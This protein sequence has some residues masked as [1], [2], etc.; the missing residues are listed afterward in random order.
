MAHNLPFEVSLSHALKGEGAPS[1]AVYSDALREANTALTAYVNAV[2]PLELFSNAGRIDD[3]ATASIVAKTLGQNTS[4]IYVLGTGGSS[5]GGQALQNL[6]PFGTKRQPYVIFLDNPDPFTFGEALSSVDLRTTRFLAISKSGGTAE[7]LMQVLAAADALRQAGGEKYLKHH[8]AVVTEPKP[9]P[10]RRFAEEIGCPVLDHPLG[11]GGRYSVLSL[12]GMLPA[13]LMGLDAGAVRAGACDVLGG[14]RNGTLGDASPVVGAALHMAL[15][16]AGQ[17]RET[18]LWPYC[19]RLKTFG[20]WWRQLWAESLGKGGQGSTPI[21]A[22]GPVDQHS[23]L[24]LFLDGPGNSLFTVVTADTVGRGPLISA[25]AAKDLGAAYL[26]AWHMGD[27]VDAEARATVE[28]LARRGRPVRVIHLP[29]VDERAIGA[30]F[31]HFMLETMVTGSIMAID[32]FDQPAVE[33]GKILARSY[34]EGRRA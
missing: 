18:I 9:S 29:K 11:I 2:Q 26:G 1:S 30:L 33:E 23:Q 34:L 3:L 28:T 12:V 15:A 6:L 14:C 27:L 10:L 19:D 31:M 24:Q 32:P 16:R 21:A 8:F 5:L 20:G 4:V 25:D 7:T 22:L 17:L 13:L